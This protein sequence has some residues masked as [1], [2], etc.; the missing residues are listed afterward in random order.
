MQTRFLLGPAGSGK[1]FQCLAEIRRE[2]LRSPDGLPLLLLAPKQATFQLERQLLATGELEGYTRLEIF[3]F[4]RLAQFILREAGVEPNWLDDEGR[5]MVLRALLNR[6]ASELKIFHATARLP[7]F[8][9]RL[10]GLFR[11]LQRHQISVRKLRAL[12]TRLTHPAQLADKLGDFALLL[13]AY[14]DWLQAHQ[15]EDLDGLQTAAAEHLRAARPPHPNAPTLRLGG[16]WMDG[17]AELTAQELDLLAAV[18]PVAEQAT[19]AFCLPA[20][21]RSDPSWLSPWSVIGQTFRRCRERLA[22]L[23]DVAI[24]IATLTA[25]PQ[26]TRFRHAPDLAQLAEAWPTRAATSV[27]TTP[28]P[29]LRA[30]ACAN[31]EAEA[32]LAA[33][34]IRRFVRQGGRYR[35]AAV[36]LR[37]LQGY[38]Y[39]LRRVFSRYDIPFF[40]DRR[41]SVSHHPL[42]ELTRCALRVVAFHW[43]HADWFGALKTGFMPVSPQAI[44][45][46]END[47][48]QYGWEG[49]SWLRPLAPPD[50][51]GAVAV[52]EARRLKLLAPFQVLARQTAAPHSGAQLA[53]A[54]RE[55]WNALAVEATLTAWTDAAA[56]SELQLPNPA[57]HSTVLEQLHQWLDNLEQAFPTEPLPL[58][59]WLPILEAGLAHLTVGVIPPTL[60]QVLIGSV[61]R[62]R[63]PDL[64]LVLVL[65]LN[66]G[67]FPAAPTED[68]L[69]NE[70]ERDA[71]QSHGASLGAAF[72]HR[73][74]HEWFYGYI[75]CTRASERLVLTCARTDDAGG[76]L[77][78]SPFFDQLQKIF[79]GLAMETWQPPPAFTEVEHESEI[80]VPC[81]RLPA[82]DP[83]WV[84]FTSPLLTELR[85]KSEQLA[86]A[87]HERLSPDT[88]AQWYGPELITSVSQLEDYAA[89]PFKFFVIHGM[90][91]REREEYEFDARERG[92]FQH[93]VLTAFHRE[94]EQEKLRWREVS[95]AQAEA[96]V[97][98][99]GTELLPTYREGLLLSDAARRFSGEQLLL[100]LQTLI[101]VLV[102]WAKNYQFDPVR[103]E[104]G[105]GTGTDALWPACR[106]D[107]G[108]N[109]TLSLRGRIDRVDLYRDENS[110]AALVV[111]M[112]YKSSD[113]RLSDAQLY[114]G[115]QLQL[116][117]YLLALER[118]PAVRETF[119]AERLNAAGAFYINLQGRFE[120]AA[121]R[122]E[123]LD[124]PEKQ[125]REAFQ[126]AGRFD[127]SQLDKFD[128]TQ[129]NEQF[130]TS[131][132]ARDGMKAEAFRDL[133]NHTAAT[134]FR[135]G[136]E[137]YLGNIAP[138]PYRLGAKT[139]CD[140]CEFAAICRFDRWTQPYRILKQPDSARQ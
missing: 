121:N 139:A 108:G 11:E 42:A 68:P 123:A 69:L 127:A 93:A 101:R 56:Q 41:E 104:A 83:V 26:R 86:R 49:E 79:P 133:L 102:G 58:R 61:D 55:F 52:T 17:F 8:A 1:T 18:I 21:L 30:A 97:R 84:Q 82:N 110:G 45:E 15:L 31:P 95:P 78:P 10:S 50:Q 129:S 128:P 109:R 76:K 75:A 43:R 136:N 73:L 81:L 23:P 114:H 40:L 125:F 38:D 116:P 98:R 120:S 132:R 22:Q 66:E 138:A 140:F 62:S 105:F 77:N 37:S 36:L 71:L 63:N 107:L 39:I 46:L 6:H 130:K 94:L 137:I 33:R 20:E 115:L 32:T 4:D 9:M 134:L 131:A 2:L 64:K 67:G 44:D 12:A 89:C 14:R 65:G 74:G 72:R 96:R 100:T 5:I 119:Q 91:A 126:H 28:P 99:I 135:F 34:E 24:S 47:A 48:L 3:S 117:T 53:Q 29:H 122:S 59:E 7:G 19:L 60:D 111:V 106:F 70:L 35:D 113:Q 13:S 87:P 92:S 112:D 27:L 80:I 51:S 103:V 88:V 124:Y 90:R 57:L 16:L 25:D 118:V 85:A 54:V